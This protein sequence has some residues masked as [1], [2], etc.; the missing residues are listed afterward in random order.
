MW[1]RKNESLKFTKV[2][3]ANKAKKEKRRRKNESLKFTKVK[4]AKAE[5]EATKGGDGK[6][7]V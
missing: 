7:K 2:K 4:N 5:E 6:T 1:R 3:N